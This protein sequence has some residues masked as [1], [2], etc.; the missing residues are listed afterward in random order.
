MSSFYYKKSLPLGEGVADNSLAVTD[1]GFVFLYINTENGVQES[2]GSPS[3]DQF[4]FGRIAHP[5]PREG[6]VVLSKLTSL[7]NK[8]PL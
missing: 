6:L 5:P 2:I 8:V 3:P 7:T 1:E 4:A